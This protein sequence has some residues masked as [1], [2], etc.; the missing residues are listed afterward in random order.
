[1]QGDMDQL[2]RTGAFVFHVHAQVEL[3]DMRWS[4]CL[5]AHLP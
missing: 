5:Q 3:A 4:D 2:D 1:M